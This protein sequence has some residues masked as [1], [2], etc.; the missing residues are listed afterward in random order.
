MLVKNVTSGRLHIELKDGNSVSLN[1]NETMD[2]EN[3]F[4][5]D[6]LMSVHF[7]E[8]VKE[9]SKKEELKEEVK[10]Q[11]KEEAKEEIK[12][13]PKKEEKPI[14]VKVSSAVKPPRKKK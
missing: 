9:E 14:K 12:E 6:R 7:L 5:L 8:E 2:S 3:I 13:E 11:P 10:E 4:A 1:S